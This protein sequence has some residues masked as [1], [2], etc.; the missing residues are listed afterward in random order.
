[1]RLWMTPEQTHQLVEYAR[2][3]RPA[4][5][6]GLLVGSGEQ[7][8]EII[9]LRNIAQNPAHHYRIDDEAYGRAFFQ[10][11]KRGLAVIAF[12]HSHPTGDPMPSDEDIRQAYYPDIP[13][14]IIGLR[15]G[16]TRLAAWQMRCGQVNPVEVIINLEAPPPAEA[17]L[18]R[19]QKTAIILSAIIV[20][21]FMIILS[22]SLLPPAPIIVTPVP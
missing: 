18:S 8:H 5:A 3:E 10:A 1:M 12:Y 11:Q 13:Y 15:Q 22:L 4:E 16:R 14:V 20:F 19:A 7:V 21:A 9:P 17:P 6:C 2:A